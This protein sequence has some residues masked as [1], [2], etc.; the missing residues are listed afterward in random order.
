[1]VSEKLKI[2][3]NW[4]DLPKSFEGGWSH[5]DITSSGND[6]I[7]ARTDYSQNPWYPLGTLITKLKTN[8]KFTNLLEIRDVELVDIS[9]SKDIVLVVLKGRDNKSQALRIIK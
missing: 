2:V 1:S 5:Y 3:K 4:G 8:G 7:I 6:F 9:A